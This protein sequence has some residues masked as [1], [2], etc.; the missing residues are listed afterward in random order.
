V[1]QKVNLIQIPYLGPFRKQQ[2][3]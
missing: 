2:K 1:N 3:Q